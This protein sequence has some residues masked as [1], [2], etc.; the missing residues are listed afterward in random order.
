MS[1]SLKGEGNKEFPEALPFH[2]VEFIEEAQRIQVT[3][4]RHQ[5]DGTYVINEWRGEIS[6][7]FTLAEKLEL[8]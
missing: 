1:F 7:V 8:T 6:D 2:S 4:C 3:Y 5:Y